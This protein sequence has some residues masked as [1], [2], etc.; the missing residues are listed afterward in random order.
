MTD[1]YLL[2]V[3]AGDRRAM[4]ECIERY[5][6][7]VWSLA[8]RLSPS[9]ADAEDAV[10]EIFLA[11][12]QNAARFDAER[13]S[14]VT[15]IAMIARR[16]LVDRLRRTG[17]TAGLDAPDFDPNRLPAADDLHMLLETTAEARR[18]TQAL[19]ELPPER[20]QVVALSVVEGMTQEEIARKTQLPLG[21]VKSHL[22]RGLL[23]VR[24]A[25]SGVSDAG[26]SVAP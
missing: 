8:L 18:A 17:R 16:R 21:T 10:Q 3:A 26:R 4:Q 11:L 6:K 1:A 9:R 2:R 22:R 24:A 25:L 23:A 20:R 14:E 13:A 19:A 7:L 15:F 12:W 5:S